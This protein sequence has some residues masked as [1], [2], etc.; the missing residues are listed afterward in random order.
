MR[1]EPAHTLWSSHQPLDR[2]LWWSCQIWRKFCVWHSSVSPAALGPPEGH[3]PPPPLSLCRQPPG[4]SPS[5]CHPGALKRR[6]RGLGGW[7]RDTIWVS[8]LSAL[9]VLAWPSKHIFMPPW[10][11]TETTMRPVSS[12]L[13]AEWFLGFVF[14]VQ[15]QSKAHPENVVRENRGYIQQSS[16]KAPETESGMFEDTVWTKTLYMSNVHNHLWPQVAGT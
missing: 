6:G 3:C 5:G 9:Y 2:T 15:W 13:S 11:S 10:P 12:W 8:H 14:T 7:Q 1:R 16:P 4:A